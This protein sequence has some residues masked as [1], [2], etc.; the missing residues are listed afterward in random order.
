MR[1]VGILILAAVGVACATLT[2]GSGGGLSSSDVA[3]ATKKIGEYRRGGREDLTRKMPED[4]G[5][6]EINVNQGEISD[7]IEDFENFGDRYLKKTHKERKALNKKLTEAFRNSAAKTI[8]NFGRTIVPVV[9]S[10]AEVMKHVQVNPK[11]NQDCA[12]KCLDP[13]AGCENMY[14]NEK[15][16]AS[17]SCE[18]DLATLNP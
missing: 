5:T 15:C 6:F 4:E 3:G 14:F 13:K 9:Q 16:L 18:F 2:S 17:C 1:S 7:I 10:W 11:C 8:L 12:V